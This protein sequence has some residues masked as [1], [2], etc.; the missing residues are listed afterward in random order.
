MHELASNVIETS[1]KS[2]LAQYLHQSLCSPPKTTL[3]AAIKNNQLQSFP[4]LTYE[5]ISK[6]LPP[7]TATDK[8]HLHRIRQGIR[9][10]RSNKQDIIDARA[11]V[12]AMA[13]TEEMCQTH[14]IFCFAALADMND[15]TMY[16]DLTGQFPVRSYKNMVYIF[17]A[18]VYDANAILARAM[19]SRDD[20]AMIDAF[21]DIINH[22]DDQGYKPNL[23]VMDNE[24]SKAVEKFIKKQ[25]I[26][27]QL[28]APHNHRVNAAERAIRTFKEHFIAALATI[29]K[30]CPLQLWDQFLPQVQDT[31]NMLRRCR[32][33]STISAYEALYG[34]FDFNKTPLA[35]IGTKALI[36]EG[37]DTRASWAPHGIDGYYVGPAKKHYR[38][39]RFWIPTT[40]RYRISD[41]YKLYPTHYRDLSLSE[42]DQ[43]I[44]AGTDLL[45]DLQQQPPS[46]TMQRLQHSKVIQRLTRILKGMPEPRVDSAQPRVGPTS[47]SID[48][49]APRV[50]RQQ[51]QV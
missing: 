10:T 37:P 5:L 27:I 45:Q 26:T 14:D 43:S 8:G 18:Y 17:I 4:G 6:H 7:S 24:C 28:V 25:N 12:D 34:I 22:L 33:D 48:A 36:Y 42:L 41:T 2:E 32:R 35:P 40:R 23:N 39:L 44:I 47:T 38:N 9:S 49:T 15:G 16:T 31:L 1:T 19:P 3:L 21:N 51:P 30:K 50:V 11:E 29:D 20:T 13:P 46:S